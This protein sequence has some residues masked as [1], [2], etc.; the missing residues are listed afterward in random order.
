MKL[1]F[2]VICCRHELLDVTT[3]TLGRAFV[4]LVAGFAKFVASSLELGSF[5]A[6]VT[7]TAGAG[8]YAFVVT[9]STIGNA[10]LVFS[11]F[12]SDGAGLGVDFDFSRTVVGNNVSSDADKGDHDQNCNN[13]SHFFF[14]LRKGSLGMDYPFAYFC[15]NLR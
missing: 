12:E 8:F 10:L 13:F 14:L 7:A 15:Q 4:F 5:S 9:G 6:I 1:P 3:F 2:L 11:M